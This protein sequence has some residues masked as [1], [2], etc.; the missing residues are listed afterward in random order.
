V[1]SISSWPHRNY[2][3]VGQTSTDRDEVVNYARAYAAG[4]QVDVFVDPKAPNKSTLEPG[5][6]YRNLVPVLFGI[7]MLV[8]FLTRLLA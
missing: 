1:N 6:K 2:Q 8:F 5:L 7:V 4:Q 3:L